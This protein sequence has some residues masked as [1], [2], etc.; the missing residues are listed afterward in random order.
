[1]SRPEAEPRARFCES[2]AVVQT[3]P[4]LKSDVFLTKDAPT[5]NIIY[6]KATPVNRPLVKAVINSPYYVLR[7]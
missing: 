5:V 1:M 4:E 3:F 7:A 6:A 2:A